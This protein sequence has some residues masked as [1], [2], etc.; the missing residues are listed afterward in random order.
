ALRHGLVDPRLDAPGR[1]LV[2]HRTDV[3]P[4]FHRVAHAAGF[5]LRDEFPDEGIGHRLLHQDALHADAVLAA[6]DYPAPHAAGGGQIQ[7]GILGHDHR[8]VAAEFQRHFLAAGNGLDVPAHL[9]A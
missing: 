5:D 1:V 6:V 9:G 8:A 2:D 7:V 4:L 3:D